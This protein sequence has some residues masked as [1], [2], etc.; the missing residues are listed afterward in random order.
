[1]CAP[2]DIQTYSISSFNDLLNIL[3]YMP[4][5]HIVVMICQIDNESIFVGRLMKSQI[6][7]INLMNE[8]LKEKYIY[9]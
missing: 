6:I 7:K 1:M 8:D 3:I 4:T 5:P 2:S 9:W